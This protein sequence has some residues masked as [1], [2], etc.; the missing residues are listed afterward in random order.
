MSWRRIQAPRPRTEA[1]RFVNTDLLLTAG[2]ALLAG[3]AVFVGLRRLRFR[4]ARMQ[5]PDL[6]KAGAVVVDVRSRGEFA[7]GSRRGSI[8]IPL[9]EFQRGLKKL[10]RSKPV[11]LCCASGTRSAMAERMLREA[12]F[13]QVV[14]AG[15]WANISA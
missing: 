8:N 12:G 14:N 1:W 6:L 2:I 7:S 11:I 13:G 5:L 10:D 3:G 4:K 15:S 9:D